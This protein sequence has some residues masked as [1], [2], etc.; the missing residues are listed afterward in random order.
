MNCVVFS[1]RGDALASKDEVAADADDQIS[2]WIEEH[3]GVKIHAMSQSSHVYHDTDETERVELIV[4][5]IYT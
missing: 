4:I 1:M 3:K 5:I 2:K